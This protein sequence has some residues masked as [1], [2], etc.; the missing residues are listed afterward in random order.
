MTA[1]KP[2][3]ELGSGAGQI[4]PMKAIDPGLIYDITTTSYIRFL[5]KEGY[6]STTIAL[7]TGGMN[8]DCSSFKPALGNDGLNYPTFHIQLSSPSDSISATFYRTVTN[9]GTEKT[10][11]RANIV[12]P[13]GLD[14]EVVPNTLSFEKLNEKK[15]FK[16]LLK[17]GPIPEGIHL[18]SALLE[19]NDEKHSVKSSIVVFKP[20]TTF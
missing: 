18:Y 16:I 10:I 13:Q 12:S 9:V 20:L 17:G 8:Y 5:C 19:W 1:P 7:L 4:S 3:A 14:I 6:N 15:S 11:Y 2:D